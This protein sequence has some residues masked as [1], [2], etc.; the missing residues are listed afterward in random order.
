MTASP[1]PAGGLP[2]TWLPE[3]QGATSVGMWFISIQP[4]FDTL[5][6]GLPF[7]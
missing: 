5:L 6:V 2:E 4:L 3:P 1:L 7:R